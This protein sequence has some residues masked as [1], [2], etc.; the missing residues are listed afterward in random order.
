MKDQEQIH[1]LAEALKVIS[2]AL[3][4]MDKR[5]TDNTTMIATIAG[6][7]IEAMREERDKDE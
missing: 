4:I 1:Q 3:Q 2:E 5:I 6:I 7:D